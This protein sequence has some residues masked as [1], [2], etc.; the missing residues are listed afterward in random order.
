[1][2]FQSTSIP[3]VL[4]IQPK[5]HKD[6]R[7]HFFESYKKTVFSKNGL[8]TEFVQDNQTQSSKGVLRG[9]HFQLKYAQGK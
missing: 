7:G 2:I 6:N 8:P 3:D 5:I 9:L 4:I 1:M